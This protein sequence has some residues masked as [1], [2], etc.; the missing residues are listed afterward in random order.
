M[1]LDNA[2]ENYLDEVYALNDLSKNTVRSYRERLQT[3][4][5]FFDDPEI[6][7]TSALTKANLVKYFS[8]L[9]DSGYK[10][11]TI[12]AKKQALRSFWNWAYDEGLVDEKHD[13]RLPHPPVPQTAYLEPAES[14]RMEAAAQVGTTC[15][16]ILHLRDRAAFVLLKETGLSISALVRVSVTDY[17]RETHTLCVNSSKLLLSD[18]ACLVLDAYLQARTIKTQGIEGD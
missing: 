3:F 14:K 5:N 15:S 10:K 12:Y 8:R 4:A 7:I 11:T 2:I 17:D 16:S 1:K 13:I 9:R 18:Q 6:D